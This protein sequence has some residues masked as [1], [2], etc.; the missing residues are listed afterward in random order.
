MGI[1][2]LILN[3][4]FL[5]CPL[6]FKTIVVLSHRFLSD[7]LYSTSDALAENG[8]LVLVPS[9]FGADPCPAK[10]PADFDFAA[11]K[12]K[13]EPLDTWAAIKPSVLALKA[14]LGFTTLGAI[15]HCYGAKLVLELSKLPHTPLDAA[16]FAHPS[17][18]TEEDLQQNQVPLSISAAETDQLF[19]VEN[20]HKAEALLKGKKTKDGQDLLWQIF[21]YS[22]VSHGFTIR[23]DPSI[24]A[25][26][27]A[28]EAAFRQVVSWFN[29]WL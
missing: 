13:H 4:K 22:G 16:Y 3:C 14:K 8:Y 17:F 25:Q 21:L 20:R 5:P 9:L 6:I 11:W 28:K 2:S 10:R 23:G 18:T 1:I 24:R 27:I 26:R 7:A 29:E 12:S 19:T 15:G